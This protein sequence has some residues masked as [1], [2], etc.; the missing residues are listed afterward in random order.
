ME[1]GVFDKVV[2]LQ[3]GNSSRKVYGASGYLLEVDVDMDTQST[4]IPMSRIT[5][6]PKSFDVGTLSVASLDQNPFDADPMLAAALNRSHN[7][8]GGLLVS[9][10]PSL[11]S[12]Q[13][14]RRGVRQHHTNQLP[15]TYTTLNTI[16]EEIGFV[17]IK[18]KHRSQNVVRV[19]DEPDIPEKQVLPKIANNPPI[20]PTKPPPQK[21]MGGNLTKPEGSVL[22]K[23]ESGDLTKIKVMPVANSEPPSTIPRSVQQKTKNQLPK[24]KKGIRKVNN[25]I[26]HAL[27][28]LRRKNANVEIVDYRDFDMSS[29]E[30]STPIEIEYKHEV[31]NLEIP[32]F[33]PK[34]GQ[35]SRAFKS[36]HFDKLLR[37]GDAIPINR[38]KDDMSILHGVNPPVSGHNISR[39]TLSSP[40]PQVSF[41]HHF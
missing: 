18:K 9:N 22:T 24:V 25:A 2:G 41:R 33:T 3:H 16:K 15:F 26:K 1:L 12:Y 38:V 7:I 8:H 14:F 39:S 17:P 34:P 10:D 23:T 19:V 40:L 31:I 6:H 30:D 21:T 27:K 4:D 29:V 32:E 35:I 28:K 13:L 37:K 5:K 36:P 11:P 20:P